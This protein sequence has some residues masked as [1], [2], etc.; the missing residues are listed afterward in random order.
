MML[1]LRFRF[2]VF[3]S[4]LW[5]FNSA[6][7]YPLLFKAVSW[8]VD[9]FRLMSF[10]LTY[11]WKEPWEKKNTDSCFDVTI[12][13]YD[14][15]E[16]W[17]LVGIYLLFLLANIIDK[18]NSG[19]YR[20]GGLI[21]SRNVNRQNMDRIRKNV[22][23]ILKEVG[24]KIEI[25]TNLKIVDVLHVTFNKKMAHIDHT[26]NLMIPYYMSKHPPTTLLK[27][28]NTYHYLSTKG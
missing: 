23:K 28:S 15:A 21:L 5:N 10:C 11:C 19:L 26:K 2:W 4:S 8:W 17:G 3:C 13:S 1:R 20:E 16:I 6:L 18:K 9:E 22:I 14:G 24:F 25:K 7:W 12:G 27:S